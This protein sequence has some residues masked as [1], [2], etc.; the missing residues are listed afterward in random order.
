L[1]WNFNKGEQF[2]VKTRTFKAASWALFVSLSLTACDPP[3]PL[4]LIVLEAEKVIQC[5][6]GEV[7]AAVPEALADLATSWTDSLIFACEN[8]PLTQVDESVSDPDLVLAEYSLI[9][10]RCSP[11]ATVPVAMDAAVLVVNIPDYFELILTPQH[12]VDIFSGKITNWSDPSIG[13]LNGGFPLPDLQIKLPTE[14]TPSAKLALS[15]WIG[16][17]AGNPLDLSSVADFSGTNE[18]ELATPEEPGEIKISSYSSALFL[19]SSMVG[20]QTDAADFATIIRAEYTSLLSAGTQLKTTLEGQNLKISLDPSIE[21][22][23][24]AGL[25]TPVTPY[26]AVYAMTMALCGED[27]TRTRTMARYLLRQDSQGVILSATL[28]PLPE[29]VRVEAVGVVIVGLPLPAPAST[30]GTEVID[31][32]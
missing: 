4:E 3:M 28:M 6:D 25:D 17:L 5:E 9:A 2:M 32:G 24:E 12:I 14:A 8:M 15:E 16:R 26:Q 23:A 29:P 1:Y 21:P 30:E 27:T 31:E 22:Q 7:S 13:D 19:S 11:F 10:N 20:V 18:I